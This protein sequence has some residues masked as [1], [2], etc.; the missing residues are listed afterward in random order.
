MS[1]FILFPIS[2][3]IFNILFSLPVFLSVCSSLLSAS[4][5]QSS[6]HR[7]LFHLSLHLSLRFHL[8]FHSHRV[9]K[10]LFLNIIYFAT[11]IIITTPG[12]VSSYLTSF[13]S[14]SP[15]SSFSSCSSASI[16]YYYLHH[17]HHHHHH[18]ALFRNT[19]NSIVSITP[20]DTS[21]FF[22]LLHSTFLPSPSS[23][24]PS[25]P[26]KIILSTTLL[27]PHRHHRHTTPFLH[28]QHLLPATLHIFLLFSSLLSTSAFPPRSSSFLRHT[29]C[30]YL[31]VY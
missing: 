16:P 4:S 26:H 7:A 21:L 14:S 8:P 11:T 6:S 25:P 19:P 28:Q 23:P 31:F 22:P 15:S 24:S 20:P 18:T 29:L 13:P 5:P 27:P 9:P 1:V 17:H 12:S 10:H 2:P 3:S 30:Y